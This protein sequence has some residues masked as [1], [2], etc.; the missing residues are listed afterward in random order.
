MF[1]KDIS[2]LCKPQIKGRGFVGSG[3]EI[4]E[5]QTYYTV[6][7]ND[8][9]FDDTLKMTYNNP[10]FIEQCKRRKI[11]IDETGFV[12]QIPLDKQEK[13]LVE[14]IDE[15]EDDFD[16]DDFDDDVFKKKPSYNNPSSKKSQSVWDDLKD[17]TPKPKK[18]L[19]LLS[20]INDDDDSVDDEDIF[21]KSSKSS[22]KS[23]KPDR[24]SFI[25][26]KDDDDDN[27]VS[28]K[29]G[30]S[31]STAKKTPS[32][33]PVAPP[34][35]TEEEELELFGHRVSNDTPKDI[36]DSKP[37][38]RERMN[39]ELRNVKPTIKLNVDK[40]SQMPNKSKI[41]LNIK[42]KDDK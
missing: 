1:E 22:P 30:G 11:E 10:V 23:S 38:V 5:T 40:S 4:I 29:I 3:N 25:T 41:K 17:E 12:E 28:F 34:P 2:N 8:W 39:E 13:L 36:L 18:Q 33:M 19:N 20:D 24:P 37:P 6:P 15:E 21:M 35:M 31:K 16:D 7:E 9:E 14:E 27:E 32:P 42:P 26:D